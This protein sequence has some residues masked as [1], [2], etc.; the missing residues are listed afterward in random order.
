[1]TVETSSA[2]ARVR[3]SVLSLAAAA[4]IG[5]LAAPPAAAG[6]GSSTVSSGV[7]QP[8][9]ANAGVHS[10]PTTASGSSSSG[11]S[12]ATGISNATK[13]AV[14]L[15]AGDAGAGAAAHTRATRQNFNFQ[16]KSKQ[17]MGPHRQNP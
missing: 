2:R 5:A 15:H 17:N 1:M 8:P 9:S 16:G 13:H 7:K 14:S 11:S 10:G 12:C 4:L 3:Q 6:C